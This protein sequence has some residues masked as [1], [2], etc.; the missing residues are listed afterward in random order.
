M[1]REPRDTGHIPPLFSVSPDFDIFVVIGVGEKDADHVG[2]SG[3]CNL[4]FTE[5][6]DR[7]PLLYLVVFL[8]ERCEAVAVH[9]NGVDADVDEDLLIILTGDANC[10]FCLS[11]RRDCAVVRSKDDVGIRF[12]AD[13][14]AEGSRC[15]GCI[16][17]FRVRN[18][19]TAYRSVD[20]SGRAADDDRCMF[21]FFLQSFF[22]VCRFFLKLFY[23]A[24]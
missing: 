1:P 7:L 17:N 4:L 16:R 20:L 21:C 3:L 13:A 23:H 14:R 19:L 5:A 8:Y 18:N 10:M 6:E 15:K 22:F 9:L 24:D 2:V 12:D 11:D